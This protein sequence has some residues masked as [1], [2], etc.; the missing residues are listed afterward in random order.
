MKCEKMIISQLEE[1]V[2][3]ASFVK[4]QYALKS[5]IHFNFKTKI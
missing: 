2:L 5:V 3:D 1:K 4:K